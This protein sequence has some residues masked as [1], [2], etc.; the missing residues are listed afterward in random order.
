MP[1]GTMPGYVLGAK[2]KGKERVKVGSSRRLRQRLGWKTVQT[3]AR[4]PEA[5]VGN[6]GE[7]A[8]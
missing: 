1:R 6:I 8:A 7:F 5:K 3:P 4:P 2:S